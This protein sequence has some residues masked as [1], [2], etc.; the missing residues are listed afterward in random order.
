MYDIDMSDSSIHFCH[1]ILPNCFWL[2]LQKSFWFYLT[3]ENNLIIK[4]ELWNYLKENFLFIMSS[5][6]ILEIL[7]KMSFLA[8]SGIDE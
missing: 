5:W 6:F 4:H 1:S 3:F 7:R 2:T 8:A